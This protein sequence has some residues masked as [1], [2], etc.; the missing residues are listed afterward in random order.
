LPP[1]PSSMTSSTASSSNAAASL[2]RA[3]A[4]VQAASNPEAPVAS[5]ESIEIVAW[6]GEK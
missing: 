4:L 6:N 1:A 2:V 5:A 3:P